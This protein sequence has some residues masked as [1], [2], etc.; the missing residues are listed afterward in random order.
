MAFIVPNAPYTGTGSTKYANINQSEPDSVDLEIL[1]NTS[2][3]VRSGGVVTV[4]ASSNITVSA[5]VAVVNGS[6]YAFSS[7]SVTIA[8][9]TDYRF[10]L[11]VARLSS[12]SVSVQ[13]VSGADSATNPMLP[14]S[15]TVLTGSETFSSSTNY[16]PDTDVVLAS[17]FKNGA[18][19]LTEASVVDKRVVNA[20]PVTYTGGS[21]PTSTSKDTVG[22]V[23]VVNT[24]VY[25]KVDSSTWKIMAKRDEVESAK[26]PIG[27]MFPW[28]GATSATPPSTSMYLECN[29]SEINRA[30]YSTLFGIIG[31]TY[32]SGNGTSTFNLPNLQGDTYLVG[33]IPANV[34]GAVGT[35]NYKISDT[36][37]PRHG[38]G[39]GNLGVP[40]M[41]GTVTNIPHNH[42]SGLEAG[43]EFVI[44]KSTYGATPYRIP[45]IN[46][47]TVPNGMQTQTKQTTINNLGG[48]LVSVTTPATALVGSLAQ[49]GGNPAFGGTADDVDN[50][51]KSIRVRWFIRHT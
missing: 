16:D 4:N 10:D 5:G 36:Q 7:F 32:G 50:R 15:R 48:P 49:A 31:T 41:Q 28:A 24:D 20:S 30:T 19:D 14:K 38:H 22:D 39:N 35:N 26:I 12:G 51:P 33:A 44:R 3:Y 46:Y 37:L 23:I 13:I 40:A 21:A 2:N 9:A 25:V 17:I 8:S 47:S 42:L 34:G 27:G 45:D 1:G 43:D 18:V 11:V 29:G 6:P